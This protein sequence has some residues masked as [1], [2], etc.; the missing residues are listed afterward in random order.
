MNSLKHELLKPKCGQ[1]APIQK[2]L[3]PGKGGLLIGFMA[4]VNTHQDMLPF[5][6]LCSALIQGF[7][8][9]DVFYQ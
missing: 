6:K 5:L 9:I 8:F 4:S 1:T 3:G 2:L 7:L